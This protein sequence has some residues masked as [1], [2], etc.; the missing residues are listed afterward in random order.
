MSYISQLENKIPWNHE[1]PA[2]N[3]ANFWI[4]GI[5]IKEP[6]T[7]QQFLND[8]MAKTFISLKKSE[9]IIHSGNKINI[10]KNLLEN[11]SMTY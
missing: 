8:K 9:G 2:R 6:T 3:R 1:L 11:S 4:L 5:G 10:R 7:V